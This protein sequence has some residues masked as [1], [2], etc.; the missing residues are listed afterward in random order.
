ML[1]AGILH[2]VEE[3]EAELLPELK[4]ALSRDNG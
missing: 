3:E 4:S 2:H 1:K